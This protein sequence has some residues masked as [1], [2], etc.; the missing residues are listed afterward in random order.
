MDPYIAW[1]KNTN[2]P[3]FESAGTYWRIYQNALV[4]AS[5]KPEPVQLSRE[6]AQGLLEKSG[7]LFLRY[8]TRTSEIPTAFWYTA[9]NEYDNNNLP[10]KVRSHIRRAYKDCR[11][12]RIDPTWLSDNGYAC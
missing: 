8:F 12:E 6:Q 11:V 3:L 2:Q 7:A 4:P 10:P 9:C 5:L 1:L